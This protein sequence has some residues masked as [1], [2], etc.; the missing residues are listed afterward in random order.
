MN[1]WTS[2][3]HYLFAV[4]LVIIFGYAAYKL[5][6]T[7]SQNGQKPLPRPL[8]LWLIAS[9]A[10]F[11][12]FLGFYSTPSLIP[13]AL[14]PAAMLY[15]PFLIFLTVRLLTRYNWGNA[16]RQQHTLAVAAGALTFML[17][18]AVLQELDKTRPDNTTGM[19]LVSLIFIVGLLL[20][21]RHVQHAD[22]NQ[23]TNQKTNN[24]LGAQPS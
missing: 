7:W 9:A 20:L 4:S 15:G 10:S 11:A 24:E 22:K 3:A 18:F 23:Q 1:H 19:A 13:L 21:R 6:S 5:P 14:W 12:F 16:T 17:V 8:K 2:P